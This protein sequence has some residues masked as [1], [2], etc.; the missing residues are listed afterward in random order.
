MSMQFVAAQ[1]A[2]R[3]FHQE[4]AM[5]R[6]LRHSPQVCY[7]EACD[8]LAEVYNMALDP[9]PAEVLTRFRPMRKS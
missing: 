7:N 3:C 5:T 1:V 4:L 6:S 8:V 9:M 2:R